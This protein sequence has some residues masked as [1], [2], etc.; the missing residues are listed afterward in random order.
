[1]FYVYHL[2]FSHSE[3]SILNDDKSFNEKIFLEEKPQNYFYC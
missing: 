2:F 3:I 1:M